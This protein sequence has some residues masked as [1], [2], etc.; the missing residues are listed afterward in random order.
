MQT[1]N[2]RPAPRLL[3]VAVALG[4][5]YVVWGSTYLG[6]RIVVEQADPLTAMGQRYTVAGVLLGALLAAR[7]G[8]SRLRLTRRQLLGTA[9]L[10]LLLP[11]LGN[12]VV[13]V[14]ESQGATSGYTALLIAIAPLAIVVFRLVE[15]DVPRL[16][17]LV[18]VLSGF[19][20]LAL[21]VAFG[22]DGGDVIPLG[23]ALLVL[24]AGTCW[25]FG[26]YI[27]PR[28]WL[29][30]DPFVIAVYEMVLGGVMMTVAGMVL[31]QQLTLDYTSRTWVALGY[32]VVFGSVVAFSAYVWLIANA[33]ISLV[34]TYAY[35]NPV[36]AVFLGWLVLD[37]RISTTTFVGGAIVVA[38][39]A[40]VIS[41]ERRPAAP[42]AHSS[43]SG[44]RRRL[45]SS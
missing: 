42:P 2:P 13:S 11:L 40:I 20:G 44:S 37:E 18:G 30:D 39:V 27:Q 17:T 38:S 15:G 14:A 45:G 5:V 8:F 12:G 33:P 6:I 3:L 19:G 32:L 24:L 36:V 34:A 25:A 23:P 28:L 16:R 29:P 1:P 41:S 43:A 31:G 10:G 22:R 9:V 21:L 35:V 4:I 26:S 7:G